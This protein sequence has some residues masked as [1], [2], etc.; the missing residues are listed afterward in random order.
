LEL[1]HFY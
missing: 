1:G